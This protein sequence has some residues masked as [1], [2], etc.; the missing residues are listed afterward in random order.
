[1]NDY[2][3]FYTLFQNLSTP[4]I[5]LDENCDIKYLNISGENII[6]K[7]ILN[8]NNNYINNIYIPQF[9]KDDIENFIKSDLTKIDFQKE[10]LISS[11][12]IYLH[13]EASK[14]IYNN[15]SSILTTINDITRTKNK[16]NL[17]V[18]L[19]NMP[20]MAIA[21]DNNMNIAVWNN[22]CERITGY[23]KKEIIKNKDFILPKSDKL[24]LDFRDLEL[25]IKC[26]NGDIKPL[27]C[28]NISNTFPISGWK[29]WYLAIDITEKINM[30]KLNCISTIAGGIA[31]DFNNILTIILGNVY[32]IKNNLNNPSKINNTITNIAKTAIHAKSLTKQM[33]DFSKNKS[34]LKDKIYINDLIEDTVSLTLSGS[35]VL[36]EFN[37]PKN[38]WPVE[39]DR[40]QLSQV[41]SNLIINAYQSMPKGGLIKIRCRNTQLHQNE[42]NSLKSGK[43]ITITIKDTGI[44]ICEKNLKKIFDPY[45]T[46]KKMGSGLGLTSSFLIIKKH[47]GHICV[48][49]K[50]GKGTSFTIY[51]PACESIPSKLEK[52]NSHLIKRQNKI[53]IMDDDPEIRKILDSMLEFLGY[54]VVLA[55]NGNESIE[56]Y[57]KALLSL[58]PFDAVILD[59]TVPGGMGGEETIKHLLNI[60]PNVCAI[61]SSGYSS[62]N[63]IS[64]YES[65]GF[66]GSINKP[67]TIEDLSTLLNNVLNNKQLTTNKKQLL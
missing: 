64:N 9:I 12:P 19:E 2:K 33:L 57:E 49:S 53:L 40:G 36:C 11:E 1:M 35:N 30:E 5:I 65:Y 17:K 58:S 42:I 10:V 25:N 27:S 43:Y 31:H 63:I 20:I 21:F 52:N 16:E 56:I 3:Q 26:K 23:S 34:P 37:I 39:V 60:D 14:I 22:E 18:I 32:I 46:T 45:F 67:Y 15:I 48:K 44:G 47:D 28:F 55:K 8:S 6:K 59:L 50:I 4:M 62:G 66:K 38:L 7:L 24:T 29:F 41:I 13:I 61:I 54:T 51:L